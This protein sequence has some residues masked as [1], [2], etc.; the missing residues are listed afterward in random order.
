MA[1]EIWWNRSSTKC[2]ILNSTNNQRCTK[3]MYN[4]KW[5]EKSLEE[6]MVTQ[7]EWLFILP[8]MWGGAE[9]DIHWS[10]SFVCF[11]DQ[12]IDRSNN[13]NCLKADKWWKSSNLDRRLTSA[14]PKINIEN[15]K[16]CKNIQND[17]KLGCIQWNLNSRPQPKQKHK[18]V[19]SLCC[20]S[21]NNGFIL[22]IKVFETSHW[23]SHKEV[24]WLLVIEPKLINSV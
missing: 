24:I 13:L 18:M 23:A 10:T 16:S 7:N 6:W 11:S 19:L 4:C 9:I 20:N 15:Y 2:S 5:F 12:I 3:C 21:G 17:Y 1:P 14:L 22:R 8:R